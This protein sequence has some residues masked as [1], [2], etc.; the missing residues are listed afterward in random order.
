MHVNVVA[1]KLH[2]ESVLEEMHRRSKFLGL[3]SGLKS[4]LTIFCLLSKIIFLRSAPSISRRKQK[5]I[6]GDSM[7]NSGIWRFSNVY[8]HTLMNMYGNLVDASNTSRV[9]ALFE[10]ESSQ[11]FLILN[12]STGNSIYVNATMQPKKQNI[13][14]LNTSLKIHGEYLKF[15]RPSRVMLS[16]TSRELLTLCVTKDCNKHNAVLHVKKS[17]SGSTHHIALNAS[18]VVQNG[19]CIRLQELNLSSSSTQVP[20]TSASVYIRNNSGHGNLNLPT[21]MRIGHRILILRND[22][23]PYTIAPNSNSTYSINGDANKTLLIG[24]S[25]SRVDCAQ[26]DSIAEYIC[27]KYLFSG[28]RDFVDNKYSHWQTVQFTAHGDGLSSLRLGGQVSKKL[29]FT[30]VNYLP[31]K[32]GT[33][34]TTGNLFDIGMNEPS[35][36]IRVLGNLGVAGTAVIGSIP[37]KSSITFKGI[38]RPNVELN[39]SIVLQFTGLNSVKGITRVVSK[40]RAALLN[41]AMLLPDVSGTIL[42]TGNLRD[43]QF[44]KPVSS[45]KI[46]GYLVVGD[47]VLFGRTKSNFAF[48]RFSNMKLKASA[49]LGKNRVHH[50][51]HVKLKPGL[52]RF[53]GQINTFCAREIISATISVKFSSA[54]ARNT[55]HIHAAQMHNWTSGQL[56]EILEIEG[57]EPTKLNQ[58]YSITRI[59]SFDFFVDSFIYPLDRPSTAVLRCIPSLSF[60]ES[61]NSR[62]YSL[63]L[64]DKKGA[65]ATKQHNIKIP[66]LAR[67]TTYGRHTMLSSRSNFASYLNTSGQDRFGSL[68]LEKNAYFGSNKSSGIIVLNGRLLSGSCGMVFASLTA[69]LQVEPLVVKT[70]SLHTFQKNDNVYVGSRHGIEDKDSTFVV[71]NVTNQTLTLVSAY[72]KYNRAAMVQ[73]MEYCANHVCETIYTVRCRATLVFGGNIT[74]NVQTPTQDN[75]IKVKFRSHTSTNTQTHRLITSGNSAIIDQVGKL[76]YLNVHKD[77]TLNGS[78]ALGAVSEEAPTVIRGSLV[79][80]K[81]KSTASHSSNLACTARSV[82]SKDMVSIISNNV[83]S[84]TILSLSGRSLAQVGNENV[85][86]VHLDDSNSFLGKVFRITANKLHTGEMLRIFDGSEIISRNSSSSTTL[87]NSVRSNK[88]IF[89]IA[90]NTTGNIINNTYS[91]GSKLLQIRSLNTDQV[92]TK[93]QAKNMHKG[94]LLS[95]HS[96][97]RQNMS[98]GLL[99]A[100]CSSVEYVDN[101]KCIKLQPQHA[102]NKFVFKVDAD[103]R[104]NCPNAV[105]NMFDNGD[106]V[107]LIDSKNNENKAHHVVKSVIKTLENHEVTLFQGNGADINCVSQFCYAC[108]IPGSLLSLKG[109]AQKGGVIMSVEGEGVSNGTILQ[110]TKNRSSNSLASNDAVLLH[111]KTTSESFANAALFSQ[112]KLEEVNSTLMMI[113]SNSN[114]DGTLLKLTASGK[115]YSKILSINAASSHNQGA[116]LN[117]DSSNFNGSSPIGIRIRSDSTRNHSL[118]RINSRNLTKTMVFIQ[119]QYV[120]RG[121]IMSIDGSGLSGLTKIL[122]ISS[123][124]LSRS[125]TVPIVKFSL[126]ASSF[127]T[128]L[129]V[130]SLGSSEETILTII[131]NSMSTGHVISASAGEPGQTVG[132][133][134]RIKTPAVYSYNGK[135]LTFLTMH[136]FR[137]GS[138]FRISPSN[139]S[140]LPT[141]MYVHLVGGNPGIA[142]STKECT[143][144]RLG[145][146]KFSKGNAVVVNTT[147]NEKAKPL[148]IHT[149]SRILNLVTQT[150]ILDEPKKCLAC[151]LADNLV[152]GSAMSI[153]APVLAPHGHIMT[154]VS[155]GHDSGHDETLSTASLG[156]VVKLYSNSQSSTVS[157]HKAGH[158]TQAAVLIDWGDGTSREAAYDHAYNRENKKR[159]IKYPSQLKIHCVGAHIATCSGIFVNH[160]NRMQSNA[161]MT[162][163]LVH[164]KL[165][166]RQRSVGQETDPLHT[167]NISMMQL[168]GRSDTH[169][170]VSIVQNW[171]YSE[172]MENMSPSAGLFIVSSIPEM[173][174]LSHTPPPSHRSAFFKRNGSFPKLYFMRPVAILNR[175]NDTILG[176][177]SFQSILTSS[178]KEFASIKMQSD[179]KISSLLLTTR[180]SVAY[181]SILR[182]SVNKLEVSHHNT[183]TITRPEARSGNGNKFIFKAHRVADGKGGKMILSSGKSSHNVDGVIKMVQGG[184]KIA[185]SAASLRFEKTKILSKTALLVGLPSST[186]DT[187]MQLCFQ[188]SNLA[189]DLVKVVQTNKGRY[190]SPEA[191]SN[192]AEINGSINVSHSMKALKKFSSNRIDMSESHTD[193]TTNLV[194]SLKNEK[195]LKFVDESDKTIISISG[196]SNRTT[197]SCYHVNGTM[198][199]KDINGT[200]LKSRVPIKYITMERDIAVVDVLPRTMIV[201]DRK[202]NDNKKPIH[203]NFQD[204]KYPTASW[205]ISI[206]KTLYAKK[207]NED[208]IY[209]TFAMN[210]K[211]VINL[212]LYTRHPSANMLPVYFEH[213]VTAIPASGHLYAGDVFVMLC[214]DVPLLPGSYLK[215]LKGAAGNTFFITGNLFHD[216]FDDAEKLFAGG[217]DNY[218][219]PRYYMASAQTNGCI[220]RKGA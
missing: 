106:V 10:R 206:S 191:M 186:E 201:I 37:S 65:K 89:S 94:A 6:H 165:K 126:N 85:K 3:F 194:V 157:L 5:W 102:S 138:V 48:S 164:I 189:L 118:L 154:I 173:F 203:F 35:N 92:V 90:S 47:K 202:S 183:F 79:V 214:K 153:D 98:A 9:I 195:K 151:I 42:T 41:N 171:S 108:K 193:R 162:D 43:I 33:I 180:K 132:T 53:L 23:S 219:Q 179:E 87:S 211:L 68:K 78:A 215:V 115:E 15:A 86:I 96:T 148:S 152:Q 45:A 12:N 99:D 137:R 28:G 113:K 44:Y 140:A 207:L 83:S 167:V 21:P 39:D 24:R 196:S 205:K 112:N 93:I 54:K 97:G 145:G 62:V 34:I 190:T 101:L 22:T 8:V 166:D 170:L 128:V 19:S 25:V 188:D 141:S 175:T 150:N 185:M 168:Y 20:S 220:F 124:S 75:H 197:P 192:H 122:K 61:S 119:G 187:N 156:E 51:N 217:A 103:A 158:T 212:K 134:L 13:M 129:D 208:E 17:T 81:N 147:V 26:S 58:P 111:I 40:R 130:G 105:P 46:E 1:P 104:N 73:I 199:S 69:I 125:S 88:T 161:S 174:V 72:G 136:H 100:S 67:S 66:M 16:S 56:V 209:L 60:K 216:T 63:L 84:G 131:A 139:V 52:V 91:D 70:S 36:R 80:S 95:L 59:N 182:F 57:I 177:L 38:I 120:E 116:L 2:S 7:N 32:S 82:R 109:N 184:S 169:D 123:N 64:N 77:L 149:S 204:V 71:L 163:G 49:I 210:T 27:I 4:I 135:P 143:L 133:L 29:C 155:D 142:V 14:E 76:K 110:I 146:S 218:R 178:R 121:T 55:T 160:S 181:D 176:A 114:A 18:L 159:D 107:K 144:L 30:R 213:T 127:G 200:L 11:N 172:T 117:I 74:L 31:D 50:V 198:L